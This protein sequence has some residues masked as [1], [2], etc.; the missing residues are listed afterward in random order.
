MKNLLFVM[1]VLCFALLT[2]CAEQKPAEKTE[3]AKPA[4]VAP[5][6]PAKVEPAKP[7]VA[8]AAAPAVKPAEAAKPAVTK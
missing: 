5:A 2:A 6:A 8:P 1:M 7:V 4:V 3:P